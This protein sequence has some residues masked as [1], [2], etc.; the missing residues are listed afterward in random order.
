MIHRYLITHWVEIAGTLLSLVYL[1][2]SIRQKIGLWL[3]GFLSAA[4]Y[5]FVFFQSKFYADMS[6]Q[7]YYMA[8]SVYGW[9]H[10]RKG[11]TNDNKSTLKVTRTGIKEAMILLPITAAVML[12]YY[13][14]L[15]NYT[16]SPLPLADS[17]TTAL[18]ITA[19]WMLAQKRIEHWILWIIVDLVSAGL[20]IYK[21]LYPTAVLFIVYT[22]FAVVGW[23]E[24]RKSGKL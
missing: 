15:T 20:Y 11:S 9:I 5:A 21:G 1:Y 10:W 6:L 23:R 14:I 7:F 24:W 19:T 13:L 18:S 22:V 3:F 8:V 16:D 2:L 12:L 4:L 17:F